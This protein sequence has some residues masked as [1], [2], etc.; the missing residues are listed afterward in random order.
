MASAP[1]RPIRKGEDWWAEDRDG[2]FGLSHSGA[3]A[4]NHKY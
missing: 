1:A 3:A 4:T 2:M